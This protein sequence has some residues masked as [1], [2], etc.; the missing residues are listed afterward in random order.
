[1]R[2]LSELLRRFRDG[3]GTDLM[4]E[5]YYS[6]LLSRTGAGAPSASEARRDFESVR[7]VVSRALI[8]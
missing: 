7:R 8:Y 5:D 1:M 4:F 6:A 2:T 3:A